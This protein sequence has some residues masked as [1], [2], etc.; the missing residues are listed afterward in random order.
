MRIL[1]IYRIGV[2]VLG[3]LLC[4]ASVSAASGSSS[5]HPSDGQP[6]TL[7]Q[8]AALIITMDPTL[9]TG[10]L[11][12][13]SDADLLMEGD[14]IVAIG[15]G[16][17]APDATVVD[18]KGK[19]VLPGFVDVHN[20]LYQSVFRGGCTD[21]DVLGWLDKCNLPVRLGLTEAEIYAAVR[22]STLD[23]ITT[24]VTTVVDWAHLFP[25]NLAKANLRALNESGL[26]FVFAYSQRKEARDTLKAFKADFIDPNPLASFQLSGST[27]KK[28]AEHLAD[29]VLLARELNVT[30]NVHLL[31]HINQR[32]DDPVSVL[33]RAGALALGPRLLVNHA[34]HLT[35]DEIALLAKSG[36]HIAHSPLSNMRLASGI[37]RLPELHKA[38]IKVGLGLDGGT[39]D[40]SDVFANMRAAVG[41]QRAKTLHAATFPTVPDVLRMATLGGAEVLGLE[42]QIGSLTPGK[43]ADVIMLDPSA[44][45]FAPRWDWPSQIVFNG[46]PAN[47]E[48]VF[49]GGRML[50]EKGRLREV[51][52]QD[53]I[54][55]A[56]Q[57]AHRIRSSL[58]STREK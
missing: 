58:T 43:K 55:A 35:D 20:H 22:L 48:Y 53:V 49:V 19:I 16:L 29:M 44:V 52:E 2:A 9:E 7:I 3:G 24:G 4:S 18:A 38:G 21:D 14:T 46:Q 13:L 25:P 11:G 45:N 32:Q 37:I 39:N 40:T 54:A 31:E 12:A 6:K 33:A 28:S 56:E 26:R 57:A 5:Q 50:K 30:V 41:L 23:L 34:V 36:V 8:H 51:S 17:A 47:V 1:S 42:Q 27:T 15:K 10:P